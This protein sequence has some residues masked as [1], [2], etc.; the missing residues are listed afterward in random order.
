MAIYYLD[1]VGGDDTKN[2]LSFEN[3][4]KTVASVTGTGFNTTEA[5]EI[6]VMSNVTQ[7]LIGNSYWKPP[8]IVKYNW[9][10]VSST[11]GSGTVT[12]NCST[13]HSF[14]EGEWVWLMSS[15]ASSV[16]YG[17]HGFWQ[18]S[19]VTAT[20]FQITDCYRTTTTV[21]NLYAY[22]TDNL[23]VHLT[24]P[25][26]IDIAGDRI[27]E[28]TAAPY[29]EN[30]I[31]STNVTFD[32]NTNL[33]PQG[34]THN[35]SL[36]FTLSSS[37][38]SA[39]K[40]AY[41]TLPATLNLTGYYKLSFW[42]KGGSNVQ[43]QYQIRLCGDTVG[44]VAYDYFNIPVTESSYSGK[45]T[46]MTIENTLS[47]SPGIKS[48]ALYR[49]N[50]SSVATNIY[51]EHIF[52]SKASSAPD[53]LSLDDVIGTPDENGNIRWYDIDFIYGTAIKISTNTQHE[54]STSTSNQYERGHSEYLTPGIYPL[55]RTTLKTK[56][57]TANLNG[58][59]FT[60][61]ASR[62]PAT[63][64][65]V[66]GGWDT[67]DMSTRTGYTWIG[68]PYQW[69]A[70][71]T[72]NRS[73][74]S[75][76]NFIF[77]CGYTQIYANNVSNIRITNCQF[78]GSNSSMYLQGYCNNWVIKDCTFINSAIQPI[79]IVGTSNNM[80]YENIS[81]RGGNNS[82]STNG[83]HYIYNGINHI[84][85]GFEVL[86]SG[87]YAIKVARALNVE[88][89]DFKYI[90]SHS[91][92]SSFTTAPI[93]IGEGG[94]IDYAEVGITTCTD[95]ET[96][97]IFFIAGANSSV[98]KDYLIT[99]TTPYVTVQ[100][101]TNSL[102]SSPPLGSGNDLILQNYNLTGQNLII[103][104]RVIVSTSTTV[105]SSDDSNFSW[106]MSFNNST[107][108]L[109][110]VYSP[111]KLR[112]GEVGVSSG[113]LVSIAASMLRTHERVEG[114]LSYDAAYPTSGLTTIT[115]PVNTWQR[116]E[117]SFS[118]PNTE[119]I[120]INAGTYL[121]DIA[122]AHALYVDNLEVTQIPPPSGQSYTVTNYGSSYY[123]IN[124]IDS[125]NLNLRK[126]A[127][128]TFNMNSSGHPFHIQTTS[129][130]YSSGDAYTSG[131]TIDGN[132]ETGV[133]TFVVPY[134][135]PSTLYYVCEY[136]SGMNGIISITS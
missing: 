24:S 101:A 21:D 3:R 51:I 94:G 26:T 52:A 44:D 87:Y 58:S 54:I 10:Q 23:L 83:T 135:A 93:Y 64:V 88:L 114:F 107:A 66:T 11:L 106:E 121:T 98:F 34:K 73:H 25:V 32:V 122:T 91:G 76:E 8:A 115:G 120:R 105:K 113:G 67:T 36:H 69:G 50:A 128:Y 97:W 4:K 20:S 61:S 12:I 136:H 65:T 60:F 47:M 104:D 111:N 14:Q 109:I 15:G 57:G 100:N 102:Y 18:I 53:S 39:G 129:G 38:N 13:A 133:I 40:I 84:L 85:K 103:N 119:V 112:L 22:R 90:S 1:V 48:I 77:V 59:N 62:T 82:R 96:N 116:V 27:P 95:T 29:Y 81:I 68:A 35:R 92:Y 74:Y 19:N 131:V 117:V 31:P 43:N 37:F 33:S 130:A 28:Q 118:P 134:N 16:N 2:G 71:L 56:I 7:S 75:F 6:R 17:L 124:G 41:Y 127:T 46:R 108:G 110:D 45:W 126:G 49:Q 30:W 89:Y 63:R 125:A 86:N 78:I 70:L 79:C 123:I 9:V 5:N 72:P 42:F 132:R 99:K 55:Y 80:T